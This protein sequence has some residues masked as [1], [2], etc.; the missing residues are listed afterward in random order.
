MA[1]NKKISFATFNLY[2]L[3]LPGLP[4]YERSKPY[5]KKE[6]AAK[7]DWTAGVLDQLKADVIGFQEVWSRQCLEDAFAAAGLNKEYELV[8]FAN[9]RAISNALAIRKPATLVSA[10]EIA[11]FPEELYLKK[12]P[13]DQ[14]NAAKGKSIVGD[15]RD[16]TM[17]VNIKKFSRPILRATI[18]PVITGKAPSNIRVCVA[19]L[20]S[21]LPIRFM[22]QDYDALPKS[23]SEK[24]IKSHSGA[25]GGALAT[26]RRAAEAGAIRVLL[27]KMT[28]GTDTPV[29][30]LGDLN[31]AQL[32]VTTSIITAQ[33]TLNLTEK[34]RGGR[35][36]DRGFYS[37]AVLQELR[38]LR[39]VYFTHI[40]KGLRES[41]DHI[42]VSEQFYDAS[43]NRIW[44]FDEM[45]IIN[46]HLDD[47]PHKGRPPTSDHGVVKAR[48]DY[49]PSEEMKAKKS[50]KKTAKK[51]A[52]TS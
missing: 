19:H 17:S 33:P 6:Y 31:D 12:L 22:S 1:T 46:D 48:F 36:S 30:V 51:K 49:N 13:P 41:L 42:L 34:S 25:I 3:Q 52:A 24:A 7:I 14:K 9:G 47:R 23:V 10:E 43:V 28:R 15:E 37:T 2:N 45:R 11:D 39:D 8:T 38:S 26:I 5:T 27:D 4:L 21:K 40:H 16:Y 35:R 50:K 18:K 20:K 44:S 29:V 32:S